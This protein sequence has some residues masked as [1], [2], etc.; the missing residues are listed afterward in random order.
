MLLVSHFEGFLPG[1]VCFKEN[2]TKKM[3][4]NDSQPC[5]DWFWCITKLE[6][7]NRKKKNEASF[8]FFSQDMTMMPQKISSAL[9]HARVPWKGTIYTRLTLMLRIPRHQECTEV[10]SYTYPEHIRGRKNI[11]WLFAISQTFNKHIIHNHR[12]TMG[13]CY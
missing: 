5:H 2:D 13:H 6:Q 11:N 3:L 7:G 8:F 12:V 1:I 10:R 4:W 9:I